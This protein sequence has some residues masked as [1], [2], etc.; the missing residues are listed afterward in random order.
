MSDPFELPC[1]AKA[2]GNRLTDAN[3]GLLL[4]ALQLGTDVTTHPER[5]RQALALLARAD[6]RSRIPNVAVSHNAEPM[7]CAA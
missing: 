6:R 4:D 2:H 1:S 7:V 3:L 5:F